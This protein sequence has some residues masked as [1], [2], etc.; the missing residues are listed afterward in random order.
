MMCFVMLNDFSDDEVEELL[1]KIGVQV[2]PDWPNLLAV[3]SVRPRARDRTGEGRGSALSFPTA[4]V[5]LNRS[6]SV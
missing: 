6:P 4:C 3:R 1:G 5:C 2:G